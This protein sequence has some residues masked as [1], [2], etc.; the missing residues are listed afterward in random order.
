MKHKQKCHSSIFKAKEHKVRCFKTLNETIDKFIW[1]QVI[2]EPHLNF[3]L[4][5][6]VY[7]P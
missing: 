7:H 6:R 4:R 5:T 2:I 3:A 1:D